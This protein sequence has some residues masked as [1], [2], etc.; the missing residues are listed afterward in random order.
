M[1]LF[2]TGATGFIGSHFVQQ[3]LAAGCHVVGLRR[4]ALSTPRISLLLEPTWLTK[5][6]DEL[7]PEDFDRVD[8]VVHLA[9]HTPNVPYDSLE[10]CLYWNL[11][12]PI[13]MIRAANKADVERFVIAGSCFEYGKAGERFDFI[14]P[15]APLEPTATY[16]A[17]KAAASIAFASLTTEL[18]LKLSVH[19]IFQ[20]F[21]EG[22]S[23][24]RLWPSLRKAALAGE[25]FPM[26]KGEQVRDFVPVEEVASQ[27]LRECSV[28]DT[29]IGIA[30][31]KN[32]G[33]GRPT[34]ISV[35][36][37][38]WWNRWNATG[39][40]LTGKVQYRDNEVMRYVPEISQ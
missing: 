6:I 26:T 3:A 2:V 15:N 18:K 30:K 11:T 39:K 8:A 19:R 17:S 28:S 4:N 7:I 12:A 20:V 16:P 37:S 9:A 32:L 14:P 29:T 35:F 23:E 10:Q 36:C 33:T 27:L 13:S 25:D 5:P 21:G 40:L 22:E 31:F 34:S 38:E 1:R 24:G